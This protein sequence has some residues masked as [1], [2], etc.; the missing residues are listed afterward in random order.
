MPAKSSKDRRVGE[1]LVYQLQGGRGSDAHN[2]LTVDKG[3]K[4]DAVTHYGV[5]RREFNLHLRSYIGAATYRGAHMLFLRRR[6]LSAALGCAKSNAIVSRCEGSP[7][8]NAT[9]AAQG[10]GASAGRKQESGNE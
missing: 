2:R 10:G 6:L 4:R 9:A 5:I 3:V 7:A 8:L 1:G